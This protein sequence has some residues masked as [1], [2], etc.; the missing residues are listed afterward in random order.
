MTFSKPC[1]SWDYHHGGNISWN[2]LFIS[3]EVTRHSTGCP[4]S[5]FLI[6]I[7]VCDIKCHTMS[8]KMQ[9][10]VA[11]YHKILQNITKYHQKC[12]IM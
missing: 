7:C 6:K 1:Q 5:D 9:Q 12:D 8:Y 4:S 10:N 2:K 3:E 11:K